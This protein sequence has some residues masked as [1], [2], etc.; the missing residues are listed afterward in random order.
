MR[1][2]RKKAENQGSA[3]AVTAGKPVSRPAETQAKVEIDPVDTADQAQGASSSETQLSPTPTDPAGRQSEL[4]YLGTS[5]PPILVP[6]WRQRRYIERPADL[7]ALGRDLMDVDV[8]ALDA[9][10]S[11]SPERLPEKPSHQLSLL[12]L[13]IDQDYRASYVVDAQRIAD[14]WPLKAVLENPATLKLFHSIGSDAKVLSARGLVASNTLD[15][16][17]VSRSL[18]GQRESGLRSMLLRAC[19]VWLDKTFQR[20][21]WSHRP[22]SPG[23]LAY[24]AQDAEMTLMLYYWL[25]DNYAWATNWHHIPAQ[26]PAPAVADWIL[27]YLDGSRP[28]HVALALTEAGI[29]SNIAAQEA[30]LRQ[31]LAIIR[32]PPQRARAIRIITDLDLTRLAPDLYPY[33]DS[34]ASEE[35]QSAVRGLGRLHD[36]TAV[37]LIRPLLGDA[38]QEVRQAATLALE[39]LSSVR[40]AVSRPP[41]A[42]QPHQPYQ[43]YAPSSIVKWSSAPH[44]V[45]SPPV[46]GWRDTLRT[47]F[48]HSPM[49]PEDT[50]K[51]GG[52]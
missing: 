38:V 33:L 25:N 2:A 37:E 50:S 26:E 20:A 9:E 41:N 45:D 49:L 14:L 36:T 44:D 46:G 5:A 4:G 52:D 6:R 16:E 18:F 51:D 34:P 40:P 28:R 17:A 15:L 31:A 21:D 43:P 7:V 24:A 48:G 12:Q 1:R 30:A 32:H 35:R 42:Y 3:N 13:A 10:F 11:Q 22:L 39:Q 23:M 8:L 19:N 47:Q 27:P 29:S